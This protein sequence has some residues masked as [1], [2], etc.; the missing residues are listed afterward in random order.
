MIFQGFNLVDRTTVLNNVLMG[1]LHQV[2]TWRTLLGRYPAGDIDIA[3]RA[4]QRV[5][6]LEKTYSRASDLSG[7]QR[8]RI[9][10]ARA[11]LKDPLVLVLD[12]ATSAVDNETEAA[13]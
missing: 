1:R 8:Q 7:G 11:I 5:E 12:E 3:A 13:I 2:P 9:A 4:L 10:I 6:I